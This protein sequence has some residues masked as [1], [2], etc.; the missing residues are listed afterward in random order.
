VTLELD[1]NFGKI[2]AS[3]QSLISWPHDEKAQGIAI[4]TEDSQPFYVHVAFVSP[5][6]R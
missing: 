4:G 3:V 5:L 1:K 6:G 2:V